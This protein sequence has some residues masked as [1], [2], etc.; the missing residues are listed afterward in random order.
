[1]IPMSAVNLSSIA[2]VSVLAGSEVVSN[3]PLPIFSREAMAFLSDVSAALLKNRT[4]KAFPDVVSFAYWCRK[5]NLVRQKEGY[6]SGLSTFGTRLGRGLALHIAPSNVPVNF[7]FSYAFALLSGNASIVRV[8][9]KPFSQIGAILDAIR[10]CID[11]HPAVLSRTAFVS[12][13][14]DGE[15]TLALSS[16]ADVRV[17]WGGDAT[18]TSIRGIQAMPRCLDVTFADRY[19][20]AMLDSQSVI[21]ALDADIERLARDFYNDTYLMD[22]NACSSPQAILWLGDSRRVGTA[23]TRFWN[24][25]H[26]YASDHYELQPA[27]VMD[28]YVQSCS[29]LARG[30]VASERRPDGYLTVADMAP[31]QALSPTMRGVGGYFYEKAIV[32]LSDVAESVTERYQTITYY[33]LDPEEIRDQVIEA[34]LRGIDRIVPVG[35]AMDI[36]LVWD[37]FDLISVMSRIVDAR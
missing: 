8:P 20:I 11:N 28:K 34:G 24:A 33:G 16:A 4:A 22:Q 1:M 3:D 19:S 14:S 17:I 7:A 25:V 2:G 30:S 26:D 9:S 12:Y 36:G 23:Q 31:G 5:A 27:V 10:S 29:D 13:P 32:S 15:G 35:S 18:V 6:E 21:E 37:G